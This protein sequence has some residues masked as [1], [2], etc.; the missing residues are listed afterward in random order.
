MSFAIVPFT[1]ITVAV[2]RAKASIFTRP[3]I[4]FRPHVIDWFQSLVEPPGTAPGS[5]PFIPCAFIAI[6]PRR[7]TLRIPRSQ[8][9]RKGKTHGSRAH[10]F[11]VHAQPTLFGNCFSTPIPRRLL[12][13]RRVGLLDTKREVVDVLSVSLAQLVDNHQWPVFSMLAQ[14]FAGGKDSPFCS[15][16]IQTLA[17][18]VRHSANNHNSPKRM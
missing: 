10:A 4:L 14:G 9:W 15:S 16:L 13:F 17:E 2:R 12:A 18:A 7:N 11:R 8:F 1:P 3:S 6:V 5:G